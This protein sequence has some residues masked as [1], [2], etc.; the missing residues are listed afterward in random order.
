M[1]FGGYGFNKCLA[2][3][4]RIADASSGEVTTVGELFAAKRR[5]TVHAL[6]TEEKLAPRA[7]TDIVWNGRKRVYRLTTELGKAITATTNHP[8]RTVGGWTNLGDL[9]PGDRIAAPRRL[10]VPTTE[11]WPR[12]ELIALAGLLSEGN[13]CHPSTLYF[14]G[15][16]RRVIDDFA[17]AIGQFPDTVAKVYTRPDGRK[18]EVQA[19][20]G[21]DARFK[22]KAAHA[23]GGLAVLSPPARSG[24]F[25]WAQRLGILGK[26][27]TS[28]FIPPAMFRLCDAD[29]E[30]FLGRLWA[31]DGFIANNALKVPF[32]AT[33]SRQLAEDVQHLLLRLGI[34][35]RIHNKQFKYRGGLKPGFTVHLLGD[36]AAE[37]FLAR[38]APHCLGRE[39]AVALLREHVATTTRGLTSKD[40]VPLEVR[41]W[42]DKERQRAG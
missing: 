18:L 39:S 11:S 40:T 1:K 32:Y 17:S 23:S 41:A 7:V 34:V 2:H 21:R 36:G 30:L 28:K 37:T 8:F 19:N 13:T 38:I 5:L 25:V 29:I 31:G 24:A 16:D 33:S 6:T 12:H 26:K 4:V 10:S 35:G 27:A 22:P 3:D 42:V 9:T 15:N 14:F 20:T